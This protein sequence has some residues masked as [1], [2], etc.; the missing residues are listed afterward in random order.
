MKTFLLSMA[1]AFA[2]MVLVLIAFVLLM[3]A[4]I[5]SAMSSAAPVKPDDIVLS[6]DLNTEYQDQPA[7]SGFAALNDMPGFIDIVTR[8]KAAETDDNVKGLYI[9]GATVGVGSSRAE[10]LRE[11]IIEFKESGK[12]VIAHTQG[13][14]GISGPSALRSITAADELWIQPGTDLFSTGVTFETEFLR[15]MLDKIDV[16]SEVYP[17]YEYKNAPNSYNETEYTEAHREALSVLAESLWT[18]SLEEIS[19]DR[20]L[21]VAE[22][23]EALESGP[24]SADAVVALKL[25]DKTGWP[26]EA[27]DAALERAGEDA[28]M[29]DIAAYTAPSPDYGAPVIAVVGGQGAVVT[30]DADGGSPF[31]SA[32]GFASDAIARAILDAGE[33]EKVKAIVFRVDSPGGS[34]TASDQIWRAIERVQEQGKPVVVSMGS[35]AASGGYYVSAGSDYIM[36]NRST[37]TGSIGIFGG[38]FALEGGF[39]KLGITFDT[40]SVGGEFA[41]AYGADPFTEEQKTEVMA[42]LQRGYDR[43]VNIVAEGRDMSFDEV[44]AIAR[45][46]VWSGEHA[47]ERGLVDEIGGF[48]DAIE[49]AS[50]LAEL[51]ADEDYRIAYF[52]RRKTGFEALESLFGVSAETARAASVLS[53]VVGDERTQMLIEELA[54]MDATRNGQMQAVTPRLIER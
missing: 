14:Y 37:I 9:R 30:G 7:T 2:A 23:R 50:E 54:V 29:M 49:K 10:E 31:S 6:I 28:E 26:E 40:I 33:S 11:A 3:V 12:F 8:L 34:P 17:L 13:T 43:F 41:D 53:A 4:L 52:P 5:G 48:I 1:G 27:A 39:N 24:K 47:H 38:K 46:R 19:E 51:E 35:V 36:A 25:M 20:G 42:W 18:A 44:H 15:G 32:P 45:G 21:T 16:V 22:V